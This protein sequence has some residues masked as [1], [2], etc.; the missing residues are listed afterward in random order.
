MHA[1]ND[2]Y[3]DLRTQLGEDPLLIANAWD[4]LP[5]NEQFEYRDRLHEFAEP[6]P[7]KPVVVQPWVRDM[8]SQENVL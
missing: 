3:R 5:S 6:D 1:V 7:G 4:R 2:R 8:Y